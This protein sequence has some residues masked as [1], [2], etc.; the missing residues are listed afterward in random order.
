LLTDP[1]GRK[2]SKS[3]GDAT[4]ADLRAAGVCPAEIRRRI[5]RLE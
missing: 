3:A 5:G 1:D 4:L 2:L